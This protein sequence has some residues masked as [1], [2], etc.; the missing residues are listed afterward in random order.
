MNA[1]FAR[2]GRPEQASVTG[3]VKFPIG[4]SVI[5]TFTDCPAATVAFEACA[6]TL[7]S[8]DPRML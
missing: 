7:K 3:A 8:G 2:S 5:V 6:D 4:V 1:H